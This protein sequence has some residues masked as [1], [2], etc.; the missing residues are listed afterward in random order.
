MK[1]SIVIDPRTED[2]ANSPL[3]IYREPGHGP[4]LYVQ[5]DSER[6]PDPPQEKARVAGRD[7]DRASGRPRYGN[8]EIGLGILAINDPSIGAGTNLHPE[9]VPGSSA[10]GWASG[11]GT[12]EIDT[13]RAYLGDR[14]WKLTRTSAGSGD[15]S[16]YPTD[17]AKHFPVAPLK[18][19]VCTYRVQAKDAAAVLRQAR[20]EV[21]FYVDSGG[22]PG[23]QV[24]STTQGALTAEQRAEWIEVSVATIA[25]LTA[26]W[27]R[28]QVRFDSIPQGEVHFVSAGMVEERLPSLKEAMQSLGS[29]L[30]LGA[31]P[32]PAANALQ[33]IS[34]NAYAGSLQNG[35]LIDSTVMVPGEAGALSLAGSAYGS[36]AAPTRRNYVQDPRATDA[37]HWSCYRAVGSPETFVPVSDPGNGPLGH[38]NYGRVTAD[39]VSACY[40]VVGGGA[41]AGGMAEKSPVD[42]NT[43]YRLSAYCRTTDTDPTD[44]IGLV[45]AWYNSTTGFISSAEY[46]IDSTVPSATWKRHKSTN[47][48]TSPS[49]ATHATVYGVQNGTPPNGTVFEAGAFK[50]ET[51]ASVTDYHDGLGYV[52]ASGTWVASDGLECGWLGT[53][54]ASAS[55]KGPL[56]NGKTLTFV[57]V[58]QVSADAASGVGQALWGSNLDTNGTRVRLLND[59]GTRKIRL[60]LG[61]SSYDWTLTADEIAATAAGQTFA[62]RLEFN[63]SADTATLQIAKIA[64]GVATS[65]PAVTKTGV[66][67]QHGPGQTAV[68]LGAYS[69]GSSP[70]PGK[71]GPADILAGTI[72][73]AAWTAYLAILASGGGSSVPTPVFTGDTP[74]CAWDTVNARTCSQRPAPDIRLDRIVGD[75]E[76]KIAKIADRGGTYRRRFESGTIIFDLE[77]AEQTEEGEGRTYRQG[78]YKASASLEAAAFARGPSETRTLRN[79]TASPVLS[80]EEL[81]IPGPVAALGEL[82]V[83]ETSA[84][85][86]RGVVAAVQVN[87]YDPAQSDTQN[88]LRAIDLT[89]LGGA[90]SVADAASN[91]GNVVEARLSTDWTVVLS[92]QKSGGAHLKHAGPHKV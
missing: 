71:L 36:F 57:G 12:V 14:S 50:L 89:P 49:N 47:A 88:Y 70:F 67:A 18:R 16:F 29:T 44:A 53:A 46:T 72:S 13:T 11:T 19:Y 66:T 56:G 76:A 52:N 4:G 78:L 65:L 3:E 82:L 34:G 68:Q 28:S 87:G 81:A 5:R 83:S 45:V 6:Y 80:F 90:A 61:G 27:A 58:A 15:L 69:S 79:E 77:G 48:L 62:Y 40:G 85:D 37:A 17:A 51:G 60:G 1:E 10:T 22:S 75:W 41:S 43:D 84:N 73:P 59:S 74:G 92:T 20:A 91:S 23:A 42:P 2:A 63:E 64:N 7:G 24:G 39:G 54:H 86:R 9:P 35:A 33:D 32:N 21:S 30:L 38:N 31:L 55:D 25:P 8:R 26:A